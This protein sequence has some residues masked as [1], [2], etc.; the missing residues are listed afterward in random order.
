M[1]VSIRVPCTDHVSELQGQ[2]CDYSAC[3]RKLAASLLN[4][5][6]G[7]DGYDDGEGRGSGGG[8]DLFCSPALQDPFKADAGRSGRKACNLPS[9]QPADAATLAA[10]ESRNHAEIKKVR[11]PSTQ[12]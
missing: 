8:V 4:D 3:Q 9:L 10:F 7:N 11:R 2:A 5:A 1:H 6:D 12:R